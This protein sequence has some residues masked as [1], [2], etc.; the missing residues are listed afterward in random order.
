MRGFRRLVADDIAK[1]N[2]FAQRVDDQV[3]LCLEALVVEGDVALVE[4]DRA[5][6]HHPVRRLSVRILGIE[7]ECPV[8]AA[9]SQTLQLGIGSGEVDA[10]DHHAL[11]Q[12]GH[13]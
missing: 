2:R 11:G 1:W 3:K 8:G 9:I 4:A 10:R 7:L 13:R 12:Q 6:V 5:N